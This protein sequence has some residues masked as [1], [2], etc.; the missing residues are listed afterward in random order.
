MAES[1]PEARQVYGF[2]EGFED[3][4]QLGNK[5]ANLVTMTRLGLPVPPGFVV[6]IDAFHRFAD[7]GE[8]PGSDIDRELALLESTT[9]RSLGNG[10][11][12]S[13]RSSGPVSM[14]GMMDTVLNVADRETLL[15]SIRDI[16]GSWNVDRAIAYRDLNGISHDLGTAAVV[17]AMVMG[18]V[19]ANSGTGV[20]FTR[21]PNTGEDELFGE[22]LANAQGEDIVSGTRTPEPLSWLAEQQPD[23]YAE[24]YRH[25]KDLEAY[26]RD[27]QDIEFTVEEGTLYILQT[28][29]GKRTGQAAV[30]IA[31]EMMREG[32]IRRDEALMNVTPDQVRSFL[33]SRIDRPERFLPV[34]SGLAAAP[35]AVSGRI[36]FDNADAR[37]Q[38][39][40]GPII[41]V[42]PETIPD[43]IQGIAAAAGVLTAR[44]GLSSHAAIVTRAMG[45]PCVCGAEDADVDPV[46]GVLRVGDAEFKRG[47]VITVDGTSGHIYSGE[48]PLISGEPTGELEELLEI[49]DGVRR[50]G[51]WAN[52]D[53][54]EMVAL[55]QGFGAEGIGLLRTERQFSSPESL[56]AIRRFILSDTDA[57][58]TEALGDL[59]NL[60][61]EDF[62]KI[63][64]QLDGMPVIV[65]LLDIPLHEFLPES[66]V[67]GD[68]R[69][70]HRREELAEINPMMGHRGVRLAISFPE[71]YR[72]QV[73]AIQDA[74]ALVDARVSVMIPQVIT[75]QEAIEIK[76]HINHSGLRIGVMIETVRAC[77]RAGRL[78]ET[79]DFFSFGT[80]DLT[81]AVF[82]FSRED[83]EKEFLT[84][85][86]DKGVLEDNPF[87][88][89]DA[90]GVGRLM[91]TAVYWARRAS[92][93][94]EMGVC[95]EHG[96]EPRSIAILHAVGVNY[97]SCSPFRVPVARLAA[98]QATIQGDVGLLATTA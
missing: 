23:V 49:A 19:G 30:R 47:D 7:T 32:L 39:Q 51:V 78:A 88:V 4:N 48:L 95:G 20:L 52:A 25:V 2:G 70:E 18:N 40:R 79:V 9:G 8:L 56:A 96:G 77:M 12:V 53:T 59:R 22:Y 60:Q 83:A 1:Q 54:P 31:V 13:V 81:Q 72:M 76:S 80:N 61:R 16:L 45:K 92:P 21:D 17:Q 29:S 63:F 36:V 87:E 89:L 26:F 34:L 97:V 86:L 28:R 74:K 46:N 64:R 6:S 75:R 82:S 50:L 27:M 58:R 3:R 5:G 84:T 90:K 11:S 41:L 93:T 66:M 55:A 94:I 43:D 68:A 42:R 98:A 65:R 33:H 73:D 57:E 38:A 44:G 91:D 62:I 14:P 15:R 24:L 67:T 85:Y 71:L 37:N 35:G 10:L 69:S